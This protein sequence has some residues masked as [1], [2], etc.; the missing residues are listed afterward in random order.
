MGRRYSLTSILV[1]TT[2]LAACTVVGILAIGY[3]YE[4][5]PTFF[6][7]GLP[8]FLVGWIFIVYIGRFFIAHVFSRIIPDSYDV[9]FE[10]GKG[11][12]VK[13]D[14]GTQSANYARVLE[15]LVGVCNRYAEL[16]GHGDFLN[17]KLNEPRYSELIPVETTDDALSRLFDFPIHLSYYFPPDLRQM[18]RSAFELRDYAVEHSTPSTREGL[19][20]KAADAFSEIGYKYVKYVDRKGLLQKRVKHTITIQEAFCLLSDQT[21]D[22]IREA[23]QIYQL[24]EETSRNN[25]IALYR[26]GQ[27]YMMLGSLAVAGGLIDEARRK[28]SRTAHGLDVKIFPGVLKK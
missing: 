20:R 23:I 22:S 3:Y 7:V 14:T 11:K 21:E 26:Q 16:L 19:F 25:G 5:I 28:L 8:L 6:S 12:S 4:R 2:W 13:D 10:L 27:A 1:G 24:L 9:T 15:E 18:L 17:S